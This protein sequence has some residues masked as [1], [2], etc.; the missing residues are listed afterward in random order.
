MSWGGYHDPQTS[1]LITVQ[2]TA[3]DDDSQTSTGF[4]C[5]A[6]EVKE[7]KYRYVGKNNGAFN[8][9]QIYNYV[10]ESRGAYEPPDEEEIAALEWEQRKG[11]AMWCLLLVVVLLLAPV[12]LGLFG[13]GP[14]AQLSIAGIF[15][16]AGNLVSR[17]FSAL[18]GG[19]ASEGTMTDLDACDAEDCMCGFSNWNDDKKIW[20]CQHRG[21]GCPPDD[22]VTPFNGIGRLASPLQG[23]ATKCALEGESGNCSIRITWVAE[24][25]KTLK[26][27]PN[28]C[29]SAYS[30]VLDGCSFC[31][32]CPL[33]LSG[34]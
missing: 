12:V 29:E 24:H 21:M 25:D 7:T 4:F 31:S 23:C 2:E 26:D 9:T 14:L 3:D 20:C 28:R 5:V 16:D 33:S 32:V 11:Y 17:V 27:E 8:Q 1:A 34:C 30:K 6:D 19:G 22:S 10:G 18:S 15:R 13:T